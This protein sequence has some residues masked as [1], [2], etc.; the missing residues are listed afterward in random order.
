MIMLEQKLNAGIVNEMHIE[1]VSIT[2]I[3]HIFLY[4]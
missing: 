3:K 1:D 4:L 2:E